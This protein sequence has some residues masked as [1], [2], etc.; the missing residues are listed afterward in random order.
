MSYG[1]ES[2]EETEVAF[3]TWEKD[4]ICYTLTDTD[5]SETAESLFSM[6]KELILSGK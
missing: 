5:G 4:G 2:V 1:S 6:A 3:L